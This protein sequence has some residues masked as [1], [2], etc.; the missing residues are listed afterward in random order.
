MNLLIIEDDIKLRDTLK[1]QLNSSKYQVDVITDFDNIV[2][3]VI[4]KNP[5]LVLLDVNL[6]GDDGYNICKLVK[7]INKSIKI[8]ILT[9]RNTDLDEVFCFNV[10]GDDFIRKPYNINVLKARISHLFKNSNDTI[11]KI[12]E[13]IINLEFGN[14]K[15]NNSTVDLTKSEMLVL[16]ILIDNKG[17]IVNKKTLMNYLWQTDDFIDENTLVV[18]INRLRKKIAEIGVNDLIC[19]KHGIGYYICE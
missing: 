8:I 16:Q 9:S 12:G 1:L 7:D 4:A 6:P 19:T 2:E 18:C 14:I 17:T 15:N 5:D 10:G 13:Y 11:F 3:Q